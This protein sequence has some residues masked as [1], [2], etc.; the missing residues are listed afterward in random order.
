MADSAGQTHGKN[1]AREVDLESGVPQRAPSTGG[2]SKLWDIAKKVTLTATM[3]S[4]SIGYG[5]SN[6]EIRALGFGLL[7]AYNGEKAAESWPDREAAAPNFA[8][9][10]G[11]MVWAAGTGTGNKVAST[12]GPAVNAAANA[13]SAALKFRRGDTAG[14]ARDL[15]DFSE[16]A[17]FVGAGITQAPAA[18]AVAFSATAVGFAAD[19]WKEDA[20]FYGHAVGAALWAAGAGMRND[21]VQ[22]AGAGGVALAELGRLV[23]PYLAPRTQD[24]S[25]EAA[26]EHPLAALT[27]RQETT[28]TAVAVPAQVPGT[29]VA[30]VANRPLPSGPTAEPTNAQ[31][32]APHPVQGTASLFLPSPPAASYA[33]DA[34]P[35]T[36]MRSL[37]APAG[38]R[39]ASERT[40]A[41][42]SLTRSQ[43]AQ[44]LRSPSARRR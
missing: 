41:P 5:L 37:S 27:A 12:V 14:G 33:D 39:S 42:A 17:A 18:R 38:F 6:R 26:P 35:S 4:I 24:S 11:T 32:A 28:P 31:Y 40:A 10:L 20:A 23:Y 25:P 43:S 21:Y 2:E 15:V 36:R 13:V 8:T 30:E 9:A 19:A 1:G 7:A 16:M 3:G 29:A 44:D 34:P 22:A